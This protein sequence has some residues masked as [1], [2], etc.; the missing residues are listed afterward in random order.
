LA[1]D[2]SFTATLAGLRAGEADA[3]RQVWDRFVRRLVGLAQTRLQAGLRG[4]VDA[5]D[6]VQSVFASFFA[7]H[8]QG[9]FELASWD[10]LWS[11]LVVLTLRRCGRK[12]RHFH[13]GRRDVRR[14][15]ADDGDSGQEVPDPEPTPQEAAELAETVRQLLAG[16]SQAGRGVLELRL[17]GYSGAEIAQRQGCTEYTVDYRLRK[18]RRR[19][20]ELLPPDERPP[21]AV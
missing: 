8:T 13:A 19:L 6:V 14:E 12:A 10:D 2:D 9:C 5:E 17:Q 16:L 18:V 20:R 7:R 11:L 21:G 4:K 15:Q 3:A 1:H